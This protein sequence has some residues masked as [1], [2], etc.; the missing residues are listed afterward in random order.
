MRASAT[1]P[2]SGTVCT[3]T[4]PQLNLYGCYIMLHTKGNVMSVVRTYVCVQHLLQTQTR[5]SLVTSKDCSFCIGNVWKLNNSQ[6]LTP[7]EVLLFYCLWHMMGF[8]TA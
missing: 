3:F 8:M 4:W 1:L 2:L 5:V 7:S 6:A